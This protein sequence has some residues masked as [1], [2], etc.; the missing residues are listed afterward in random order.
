MKLTSELLNKIEREYNEWCD[1]CDDRGLPVFCNPEEVF[2][3]IERYCKTEEQKDKLYNVVD[4]KHASTLLKLYSKV[5]EYTEYLNK[6]G[7]DDDFNQ[8]ASTLVDEL[9]NFMEEK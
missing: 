2:R 8:I 7:Y 9:N 3:F 1:D 5:I 4:E 6:Q